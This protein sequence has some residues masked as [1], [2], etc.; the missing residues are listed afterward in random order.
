MLGYSDLYFRQLVAKFVWQI[1]VPIKITVL[2][3]MLTSQITGLINI[4]YTYPFSDQAQA[5]YSIKIMHTIPNNWSYSF[6]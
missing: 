2:F 4:M 5:E 1:H 6:T 3:Q